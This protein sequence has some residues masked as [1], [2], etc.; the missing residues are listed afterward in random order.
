MKIEYQDCDGVWCEDS[1]QHAGVDAFIEFCEL[2]GICWEKFKQ[3][4]A[5]NET[6]EDEKKMKKSKKKVV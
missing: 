3:I 5:Y 4:I 6:C 1:R 2:H